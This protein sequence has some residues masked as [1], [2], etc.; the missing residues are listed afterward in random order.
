M[1]SHSVVCPTLCDPI[2]CSPPGSSVHGDLQAR[3][4]EWVAISYSRRKQYISSVFPRNF[5]IEGKNYVVCMITHSRRW[6][7]S[8]MAM[9]TYLLFLNTLQ[10]LTSLHQSRMREKTS[11]EMV[12]CSQIPSG[13]SSLMLKET[14]KG[15]YADPSLLYSVWSI[16][17][18]YQHQVG[19]FRNGKQSRSSFT[20]GIKIYIL[21]GS[22][23]D[24]WAY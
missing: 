21:T 11:P 8:H 10:N 14:C 23:S 1:L 3:I 19:F 2:D 15:F 18:Q 7:S 9:W 4:L 16:N 24:F 13:S 12:V 20:N 6:I 22:P 5:N 17:K